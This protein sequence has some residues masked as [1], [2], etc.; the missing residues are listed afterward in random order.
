[1]SRSHSGPAVQPVEPCQKYYGAAKLVAS[2]ADLLDPT[3]D[4]TS[5]QQLARELEAAGRHVHEVSCL[6]WRKILAKVDS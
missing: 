2:A 4:R 3:S 6:A 5:C 1:M